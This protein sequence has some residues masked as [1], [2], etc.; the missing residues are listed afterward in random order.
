MNDR[1]Y[2]KKDICAVIVS[3]NPDGIIIKNVNA[4][5]PQVDRCFVVDNGS[6]GNEVIQKLKTMSNVVVKC[7][8]YNTGIA[9][10]LNE[11]L[12]YCVANNYP[13]ILT[14]DQDTV[15]NPDCATNLLVAMEK[16]DAYSVGINWDSTTGKDE[17]VNYLITS[18]N[19]VNVTAAKNIG[20]FDEK[21]FI[22]SVDFDFSLRLKDAGFKIIKVASA[23]AKHNL[24][25]EQKTGYLTHSVQRYYYIYRNHFYITHKH[26]KKHKVFC[27][28][29]WVALIIDYGKII[30]FD[31]EKKEKQA[32]LKRSYHDYK[33]MKKQWVESND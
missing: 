2:S 32:T 33:M 7:L 13:L 15:L 8:G 9:H 21:L 1:N 17:E 18:G 30:L 11:G 4:L 25:E 14:M 29:K 26:W 27:I 3:Y 6:A 28:K 16:Y 19:L 12:D 5:L 20:G 23:G 22:D 24:G 31:R 10:A